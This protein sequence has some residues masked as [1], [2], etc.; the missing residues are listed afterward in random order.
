[1]LRSKAKAFLTFPIVAMACSPLR[2]LTPP[3]PD[4]EVAA[5]G[6]THIVSDTIDGRIDVVISTRL[7]TPAEVRPGGVTR[8]S[9]GR[10]VCSLVDGVTI[11]V[12]KNH[13]AVPPRAEILLSDVNRGRLRRLA[14]GRYELILEGGDAAAGYE[15]RL[16]FDRKMVDRMDIWAS[17]AGMIEQSTTYRDVSKA[18]E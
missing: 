17:E 3:P 9:G 5:I 6:Q 18:F 11:T 16:F 8:C 4:T 1:M 12:D 14:P 15:A 7:A 13:I 2:A 10:T